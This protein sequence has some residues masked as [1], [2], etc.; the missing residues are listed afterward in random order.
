MEVI[1]INDN[2]VSKA[3]ESVLETQNKI[4]M[5]V[6]PIIEQQERI[7]SALNLVKVDI[8][9][10]LNATERISQAASNFYDVFSNFR[11]N[12]QAFTAIQTATQ[13]ILNTVSTALSGINTMIVSAWQSPF[14]DW[15][16]TVDLSPA[17]TLIK[18]IDWE[19]LPERFEKLQ[20]VYLQTMYECKWFPY[21][22]WTTDITILSDVSEVISSSRGAS[23]RREQRIDKIVFSYYT[24][25]EIRNIKRGWKKKEKLE[26]YIKK[27]LGQA[28]EAHLRGEYALT[29]SS[30]ATMWEGL[31][32]NKLSG[33]P[34][35][36][37]FNELVD[38]N[39]FEQ[40]YSD[41]YNNLIVG[42]CYSKEDIIEGVPNRH[43]V[44][45]SWY[46]R[47]P[48]KKASLNAIL[49]TDFIIN[50]EPKEQREEESNG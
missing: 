29:I 45:H 13:S 37:G 27:I 24:K 15:L 34:S 32:K 16:K 28:I 39:G 33:I 50:L 3:I 41:F 2:N 42:T 21:A 14:I 49:L 46:I 47:Y 8:P 31:I 26:P 48:N 11:I 17:L 44:A 10:P 18:S 36:N 7:N 12:D 35:K 40:V 25:E 4:K 5:S 9:T 22:G 38:I 20:E 30:L 6:Q 43:G 23:K 19:G 1:V